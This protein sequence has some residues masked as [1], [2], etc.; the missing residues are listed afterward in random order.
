MNMMFGR[1]DW[2][3]AGAATLAIEADT[4]DDRP[5][6]RATIPTAERAFIF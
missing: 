6:K 1:S 3:D 2:A 4:S 5:T